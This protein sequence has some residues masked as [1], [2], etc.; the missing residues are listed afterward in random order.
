[1]FKCSNDPVYITS[2][3]QEA[4]RLAEGQFADYVK[5]I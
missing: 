2:V 5:R 4:K 1:M 3:L